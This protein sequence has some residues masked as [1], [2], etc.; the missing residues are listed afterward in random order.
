MAALINIIHPDTYKA[1]KR[2]GKLTLI[3]GDEE[4]LNERN[5]KVLNFVDYSLRYGSNILLHQMFSSD[6]LKT[7]LRD[8]AVYLDKK[9]CK[10]IKD[11]RV[12]KIRT[13]DGGVP[14]QDEK[15]DYAP[16]EIWDYVNGRVITD[17]GF[18]KLVG[19]PRQ[20]FFIGGFFEFC[21]MNFADYYAKNIANGENMYVVPELCVSI[22]EDESEK[23]RGILEN[24]GINFVSYKEA[25]ELI[26]H[27]NSFK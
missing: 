1:V 2:E 17:S 23:A 5:E 12:K 3:V 6:S 22:K 15:P 8:S 27:N 24:E 11:E 25:L 10:L 4:I 20:T 21:L 26:C 13:L 19:N 18:K 7:E 16:K 14:L 9:L